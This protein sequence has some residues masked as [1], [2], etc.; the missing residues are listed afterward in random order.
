M[1]VVRYVGNLLRGAW[2]VSRTPLRCKT[3]GSVVVRLSRRRLCMASAFLTS[4]HKRRITS[5]SK[6]VV[7][8]AHDAQLP[9]KSVH[10]PFRPYATACSVPSRTSRLPQ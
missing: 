9:R 2:T 3:R 5:C 10:G 7:I 6:R 8:L 1:M 4:G